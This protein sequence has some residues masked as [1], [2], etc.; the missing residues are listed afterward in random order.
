MSFV[1]IVK[2]GNYTVISNH[3]LQNT[4]LSN[5]ARGLLCTMLSLP[6]KWDFSV[7]G[8]AKICKDGQDGI[9]LQLD[10]LEAQGYLFR[11]RV[12][13]EKGQ[14]K[15]SD[16]IV[17][18][19]PPDTPPNQ[20]KPNREFPDQVN[21]N[22]EKPAQGNPEQL[23]TY[24]LN[25]NEPNTHLI[26]HQPIKKEWWMDDYDECLAHLYDK[27]DLEYFNESLRETVKE[28]IG[29]MADAFTSNLPTQRINGEEISRNRLFTKLLIVSEETIESVIYSF[30]NL[31]EEIKN[32]RN[33]ILTALYNAASSEN[34]DVEMKFSMNHLSEEVKK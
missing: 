22:Q 27:I 25:T 18:E 12:R 10:E 11:S 34:V 26:N 23:N 1:K 16:Y 3:C 29:Y 32:H 5:K 15:E 7:K 9:C 21:P 17:Y 20:G 31:K 33:F 8:L 28:I 13:N 24:I 2:S 19:V 4:N 30:R 6:P 14:L